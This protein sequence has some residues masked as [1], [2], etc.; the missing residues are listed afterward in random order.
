MHPSTYNAHSK[1]NFQRVKDAARGY[2]EVLI[3]RILPHAIKKGA[4]YV[5][6]NPTRYDRN[7]GSFR[8]NAR[9]LKWE[10]FSTADKGGDILSLW[11]YVRQVS[12]V[13]AAQEIMQIVQA[14]ETSGCG[15]DIPFRRVCFRRTCR[16]PK[17]T[18]LLGKETL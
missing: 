10:D 6:I 17:E 11:A 1:I 3:R 9:N 15:T 13:K 16:S 14:Q 2:E 8:I 5:A 12:Q 18:N 4:E 7:L